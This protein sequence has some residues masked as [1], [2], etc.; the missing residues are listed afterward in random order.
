MGTGGSYIPPQTA[1]SKRT[2]TLVF[3]NDG[4]TDN[5][6]LKCVSTH[7]PLSNVLGNVVPFTGTIDLT[8]Y[9]NTVIT[10]SNIEIYKNGVLVHTE[11]VLTLNKLFTPAVAVVAGDILSMFIVKV[12]NNAANVLVSMTIKE[13]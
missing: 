13:S 5:R 1:V 12:V 3:L 10:N 8:T 11:N 7:M 6:W 9:N 4:N 2:D